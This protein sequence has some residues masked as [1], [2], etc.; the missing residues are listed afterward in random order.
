MSFVRQ[1]TGGTAYWMGENSGSDV[2]Q[3][4][5]TIELVTLSPKNLMALTSFSRQLLAQSSFSIDNFIL[6]DIAAEDAAEAAR[7]RALNH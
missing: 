2:T 3:A 7:M 5:A 4:D 1:A 6:S